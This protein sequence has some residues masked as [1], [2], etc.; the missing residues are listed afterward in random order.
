MTKAQTEEKNKNRFYRDGV[1]YFG[2]FEIVVSQLFGKGKPLSPYL[3]ATLELM[4]GIHDH[5]ADC[6]AIL[7]KT[8]ALVEEAREQQK[9][10]EEIEKL[11]SLCRDLQKVQTQLSN[12]VVRC[13]NQIV[14]E[15]FPR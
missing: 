9:S 5:L 10:R 7:G 12:A 2:D 3:Q 1:P 8:E 11:V 6:N 15:I 4:R 14:D 13:T